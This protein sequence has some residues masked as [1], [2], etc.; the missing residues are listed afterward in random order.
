MKGKIKGIPS[1]RRY[2]AKA[3][4]IRK[5][6]PAIFVL[7]H[8]SRESHGQ[9]PHYDGR[10]VSFVILEWTCYKLTSGWIP[11]DDG[12]VPGARDNMNAIR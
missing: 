12:L 7:I 5:L 6:D 10:I 8:F 2:P 3:S 11:N 9:S 4:T 1:P